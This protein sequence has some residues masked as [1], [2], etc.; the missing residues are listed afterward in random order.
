MEPVCALVLIGRTLTVEVRFV[1]SFGANPCPGY[2]TGFALY[3]VTSG[4]ILF[5]LR[6]S[7]HL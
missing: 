2:R 5:C 6:L 1:T 4:Y 3:C 7:A